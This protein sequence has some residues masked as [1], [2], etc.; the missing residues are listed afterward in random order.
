MKILRYLFVYIILLILLLVGCVKPKDT[1]TTEILTGADTIF[2]NLNNTVPHFVVGDQPFYFIGAYVPYW[3]S[4]QDKLVSTAKKAGLNVLY[5]TLRTSENES[6]LRQLDVFL[7][8]ASAHGIYVLVSMNEGYGISL[9]K[10]GQFYNPGGVYGLIYDKEL[11]TAYKDLLTRVVTRKNTVNGRLYREDPTIMAWDVLSEPVPPGNQPIIPAE[12]FSSWLHEMTDLLRSL[13][14][15]H[16]V[17]MMIPG[18]IS[19]G[20]TIKGLPEAIKV[21]LDFFFDDINLYDMLYLNNQPM[22]D[23]Y[24]EYCCNYP[25]FSLGMPIV[26]QLSFTAGDNLDKEFAANYELQG[27]IY[28]DALLKGFQMGMAGATIFAWGKNE[29]YSGTNMYYLVYD[30]KDEQIV[31]AILQVATKLNTIDLSKP[32]LQFVRVSK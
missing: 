3:A 11:R 24:I 15:N 16:L 7:D 25:V 29:M 1:Q 14:S 23:D 2:L 28:R 4:D 5:L 21:N 13:D 12:D 27:Q 17:T 22:T 8:R 26:P 30:I 6:S 19:S 20:H 32:P 10:T 31:S 9:D 18:P